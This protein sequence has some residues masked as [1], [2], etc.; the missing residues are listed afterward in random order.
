MTS[1]RIAQLRAAEQAR[2]S[3]MVRN[4]E[5]GWLFYGSGGQ[6]W[7]IS[8]DEAARLERQARR[9]LERHLTFM[10]LSLPLSGAAGIGMYLSYICYSTAALPLVRMA[11]LGACAGLGLVIAVLAI[12]DLGYDRSM[13]RW[14]RQQERHLARSARGG[15]SE[16]VSAHHRR[17]NLFREAAMLCAL[18]LLLRFAGAMLNPPQ[19]AFGAWPDLVLLLGALGLKTLGD[20]VDATHRRRKWFD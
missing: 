19:F 9:L 18:V 17:H 8:A 14:Q 16:G 15:V 7:H 20:R 3:R 2:I 11:C 5:A 6:A 4:S 12:E 13:R 1:N 10:R